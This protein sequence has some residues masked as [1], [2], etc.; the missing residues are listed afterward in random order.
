[1]MMPSRSLIV[2]VPVCR[3]GW[4]AK[5]LLAGT[6]VQVPFRALWS[7]A[8]AENAKRRVVR[9]APVNLFDEYIH[10]ISFQRTLG[11]SEHARYRTG[12]N[13]GEGGI[14]STAGL[15]KQR[16]HWLWRIL[17]A[18][19]VSRTGPDAPAIRTPTCSDPFRGQR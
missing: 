19:L 14:R 3:T 11:M 5:S 1:M 17:H 18:A 15:A 10:M 16:L 6:S 8:N 4:P 13:G 9:T 7:S 12:E 2:T